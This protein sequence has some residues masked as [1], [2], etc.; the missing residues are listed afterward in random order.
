[1]TIVWTE[2]SLIPQ[3]ERERQSLVFF[4]LCL[5]CLD[6]D[7]LLCL[8]NNSLVGLSQKKKNFSVSHAMEF[9]NLRIK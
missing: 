2:T 4:F 8:F 9:G 3:T 5:D 6:R 1:M 7:V